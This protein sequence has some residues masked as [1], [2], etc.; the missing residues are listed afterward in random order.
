MFAFAT[1]IV[2][3]AEPVFEDTLQSSPFVAAVPTAAPFR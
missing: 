1:G 3:P 2:R